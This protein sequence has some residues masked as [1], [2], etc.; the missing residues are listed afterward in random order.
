MLSVGTEKLLDTYCRKNPALAPVREPLWECV[1][2]LCDCFE[3]GGQL[4]V[5]GNGGSCADA[6]HIVGELAKAFKLD[7]P[8][9]NP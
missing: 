9:I 7:R 4:L 8:L 5:C 1:A 3:R 2:L 6:D